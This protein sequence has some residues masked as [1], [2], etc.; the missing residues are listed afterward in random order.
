LI[1]KFV[2]HKLLSSTLK[3]VVLN[4]SRILL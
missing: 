2:P 1:I 3:F 4:C